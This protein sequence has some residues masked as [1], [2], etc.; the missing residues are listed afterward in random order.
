MKI[1]HIY[2]SAFMIS[3]ENSTF[4]SFDWYKGPRSSAFRQTRIKSSF[5]FC[6]HSHGDHYSEDLGIC[7]EKRHHVTY[8]LDEGIEEAKQHAEADILF[9]SPRQKYTLFQN[10]LIL[11][12]LL[13]A[14][15]L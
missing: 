3:L 13:T 7:K 15:R 1:N 6:S 12:G 9:V 2:H 11:T 5:V 8:I 10:H 14:H 4:A